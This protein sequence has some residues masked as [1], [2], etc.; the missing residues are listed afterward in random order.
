MAFVASNAGEVVALN[1]LFKDTAPEDFT[2]K[3]FQSDSTPGASTDS[4]DLT[5]CDFTGYSNKTLTRSSFNT[6]ATDGTGAYITYP[7]QSYNCTSV[8]TV[9][10]YWIE[11]ATSGD[12]IG[13]ERFAT[14][15]DLV[16]PSTLNFV[17]RFGLRT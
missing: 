9:Y 4:T 2:L 1:M 8:Q 13:G 11:D 5:I 17:P 7:E 6:A 15:Y 10:G 16:N 12:Y 3:L 14:P